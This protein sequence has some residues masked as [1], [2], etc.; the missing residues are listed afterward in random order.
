MVLPTRKGLKGQE[1]NGFV[2]IDEIIQTIGYIA[3]SAEQ[4]AFNQLVVGSNPTV[5]TFIQES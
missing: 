1:V 4:L 2:F 5:P 3:Q